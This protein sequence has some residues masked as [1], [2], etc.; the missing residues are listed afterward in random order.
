M[1]SYD[2]E[3]K[4][5]HLERVENLKVLLLS[6][7]DSRKEKVLDTIDTFSRGLVKAKIEG[8][9][10]IV[11]TNSKEPKK[12]FLVKRSETTSQEIRENDLHKLCEYIINQTRNC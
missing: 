11:I 9:S 10:G 8:R 1:K 4:R 2:K 7:R 12:F 5:L 3:R 6:A